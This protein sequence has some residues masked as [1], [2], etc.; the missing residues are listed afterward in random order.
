M[1]SFHNFLVIENYCIYIYNYC[2][3]I[4]QVP[5]NYFIFIKHFV[6]IDIQDRDINDGFISPFQFAVKCYNY[7]FNICFLE[8]CKVVDSRPGGLIIDKTPFISFISEECNVKWKETVDTAERQLMDTLLQGLCE[9]LMYFESEFL[10]DFEDIRLNK[11]HEVVVEWLVKLRLHLDK[12]ER[13]QFRKK[14]KKLRK[15]LKTIRTNKGLPW[16]DLM[17]INNTFC[18]KNNWINCQVISLQMSQI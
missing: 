7:F 4:C 9:K 1:I 13:S 16:K 12:L 18:L 11:N 15:L 17:N 6:I 5:F 14:L 2:I 3:Y 10:K 8:C